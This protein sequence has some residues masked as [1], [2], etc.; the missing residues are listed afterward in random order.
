MFGTAPPVCLLVEVSSVFSAGTAEGVGQTT[1]VWKQYTYEG[2]AATNSTT[3]TFLSGDPSND[4]SSAFDNVAINT[5]DGVP[6]ASTWA[7][8]ILGFLGVGFM[9]YGKRRVV[10]AA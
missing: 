2:I 5:I 1:Q 7:M 8:M 10:A 6:E 4:F 9:T 3:F